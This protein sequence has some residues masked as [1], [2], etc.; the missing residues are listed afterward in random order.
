[1]D[2]KSLQECPIND[3]VPQGFILG[4]TLFLNHFPDVIY[5]MLFMLFVRKYN[6][7]SDLQKQIK[8]AAEL[9]IWAMRHWQPAWIDNGFLIL[10][11]GKLNLFHLIVPTTL[12]LLMWKLMSL[13]HLKSP[14]FCITCTLHYWSMSKLCAEPTVTMEKKAISDGASRSR[15]YRKKKRED[16][17][18]KEKESKNFFK[19]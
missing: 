8:L 9:W 6:W 10:I 13:P 16:K 12:L 1:M 15:K 2:G 17:E 4:T 11:L 18:C 3:G 19:L 7:A 14:F 5:N